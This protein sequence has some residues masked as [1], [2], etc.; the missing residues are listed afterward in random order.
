MLKRSLLL[1]SVMCLV[2]ALPALARDMKMNCNAVYSATSIHTQGAMKFAELAK[3][4]SDGS[5]QITV[6]PGGSLGFKGSEL[7]KAVKDASVPMSDILMGVVAGS[8]EIFGL[9]TYP[10][11]VHSFDE[12][13][14]L[15]QA[16]KPSY[17]KACQ[18]WNQKFLY[19][20][21]WPPSGLFTQEPLQELSDLEGLKT[22][23]YDKNGAEF[24]RKAGASPLAMPWGEVYSALNTGLIDSVLTSSHSGK[25][26]KFWEVL[27]DFTDIKYAYP[28]NMLTI[29]M[30]YW[31][32]LSEDQ[33]AAML[34]AAEETEAAQWKASENHTVESTEII[35]DNGIAVA[36]TN[37]ELAGELDRIADEIFKEFKSKA[38]SDTKKA[39]QAIGM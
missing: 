37:P 7:L 13:W 24:L 32:A 36:E 16:A 39:L 38:S 20:A 21:P 26:G 6:H 17:E 31:Q 33:K 15:Y 25:N 10:R 8:E 12:A 2:F 4:Y 14:E 19:A 9:S 11:M 23:T 5:I 34:Q 30:D 22:R 18:K 3:E 27:S 28:L 1:M 35:E 29:N